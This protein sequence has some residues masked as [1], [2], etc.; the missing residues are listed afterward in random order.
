MASLCLI[1]RCDIVRQSQR[2]EQDPLENSECTMA[3]M[4]VRNPLAFEK[5]HRN[6]AVDGRLVIKVR[7]DSFCSAAYFRVMVC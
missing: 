5:N 2:Q 3:K 1:S 7:Y 6:N 4:Y